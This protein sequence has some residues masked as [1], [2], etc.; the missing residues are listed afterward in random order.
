MAPF[1]LLFIL[2][3]FAQVNFTS[4]GPVVGPLG[5]FPFDLPPSF[6]H[7]KWTN[8]SI[9]HENHRGLDGISETFREMHVLCRIPE[10][11]R[12]LDLWKR[13]VCVNLLVR[14]VQPVCMPQRRYAYGDK[15]AKE[16]KG[17][18]LMFHGYTGNLT[19]P[20]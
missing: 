14:R 15:F 2:P 9:V 19:R 1:F 11:R 16:V 4:N 17:V 3:V 7:P 6:F 8:G 10:Y 20:F 18:I 12:S 5:P 13:H